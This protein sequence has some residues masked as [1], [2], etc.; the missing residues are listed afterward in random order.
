MF[1]LFLAET[2]DDS[3]W[4]LKQKVPA[5]WPGLFAYAYIMLSDILVPACTCK[6]KVITEPV[7]VCKFHYFCIAP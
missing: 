1:I 2:H 3:L 5:V 6:V 7:C 4:V